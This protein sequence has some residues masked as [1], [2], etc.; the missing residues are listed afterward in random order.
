MPIMHSIRATALHSISATQ[1]TFSFAVPTVYPTTLRSLLHLI[2]QDNDLFSSF[3]YIIY[4]LTNLPDVNSDQT[5]SNLKM[6]LFW[7]SPSISVTTTA[8]MKNPITHPIQSPPNHFVSAF[9]DPSTDLLS[10]QLN[11]QASHY[12]DLTITPPPMDW[13]SPT[14]S[15]PHKFFK[16]SIFQLEPLI[17]SYQL[18]C[19]QLIW[20]L[21]T[22]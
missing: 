20:L 12:S 2:C 21:L 1:T 6:I 19:Q 18:S 16:Q 7:C 22:L 8:L 15:L 11:T 4:A 5:D 17:V 9:D 10:V 3:L 13:M 14:A